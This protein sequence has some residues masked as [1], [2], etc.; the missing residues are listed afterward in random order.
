MVELLRSEEALRVTTIETIAG[1][2]APQSTIR[3]LESTPMSFGALEVENLVTED[4]AKLTVQLT[5]IPV[6]EEAV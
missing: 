6:S 2:T 3:V 5:V 1:Q 4:I